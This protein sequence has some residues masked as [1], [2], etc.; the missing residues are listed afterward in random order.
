MTD[1]VDRPAAMT[2]R[3][4][5]PAA[6]AAVLFVIA[7]AFAM[8]IDV[9]RSTFGIK[10]D[11]ATYVAMALSAAHDGDLTYERRDLER[12]W[13]LYHSGPE[14][15]FL[16]RGRT[17]RVRGSDSFPFVRVVRRP[18][19]RADRLYY[20]KA[21]VYPLVAAPFVRAFGLNGI[22]LLHVLLLAAVCVCGYA[23]LA[24]RSS[25]LG[26]AL[27]TTAFVGAASVPVFGVFL[28][29]EIFNFSIVFIAYFLWL[30]KE[31]TPE[32][33]LNS[34]YADLV[35]AALLGLATYSKPSNALLVAPLVLLAW[36]RRRWRWGFTVGT[37]AVAA[38]ALFFSVNLA[39]TGEFNYQGGDRKTF[40]TTFPYDAPDASWEKRG[41][42][43]ATG[44]S[45]AQAAL[46]SREL[47]RRF[48]YSVWYFFSGRH[49]GL[50]P[51]FFPGLVAIVAWLSS[52]ARREPWRLLAFLAFAVSSL[53]ILIWLPFTWSG[54]G[55]PPGNRYLLSVYPTLFFL[56]PPRRT[57]LA[58]GLAWAGGA[59]FMAKILVNPFAA[60]KY[61]YLATERGLV[62]RLP[63]ELTMVNDL[64]IMLDPSRSRI[65]YGH[66]PTMLLYFLD[67]NAFP[68]EPPGMWVS[69]AG[70]ADIIVRTSDP[71]DHL[72][73]SA[74]SPIRTILTLSMGA[75]STAVTLAPGKVSTFAVPAGS[76]VRYLQSHAYLMSVRSSEGFV[77][78]LQNSGSGDYRNLGALM[79][80]SA[81]TGPAAP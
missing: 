35:A 56:M 33:R 2:W 47:P 38:A 54:G 13:A 23:F 11:E 27:F 26:A 41:L 64:P 22:V 44:A 75:G 48:V 8:S 14:G 72:D 68:P 69:G 74:E 37:V 25:S 61:P 29:P 17:L 20:G 7:A 12:F 28:M 57:A 63:V 46:A 31:V 21:I 45:T 73:V 66:Q 62:R 51:Y 39:L 77:P 42:D 16:K 58:G 3:H 6:L 79:R 81:V 30:D 60:A 52:P 4:A 55:G 40:Y 70:R 53:V 19:P 15:I 50:I 76:S 36:H 65:P 1:A 32:S 9:V 5:G 24:A 59:L 80:F 34:R 10:S 49:F 43:K 71:I 18:D 67:Q 78:H